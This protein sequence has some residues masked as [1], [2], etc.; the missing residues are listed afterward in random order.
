MRRCLVGGPV[1]TFLLTTTRLVWNPQR[2][3]WYVDGV[4]RN[5]YEVAGNIPAKPMYLLANLAVGGNWPG[6]PDG[7]TPF[8]SFFDVDYIKVW[9][10]NS[11]ASIPTE[12]YQA[13]RKAL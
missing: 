7:T 9:R 4:E 5:R 1:L 12:T 11:G 3:V 10:N 8:P 13:N 6:S 2:I